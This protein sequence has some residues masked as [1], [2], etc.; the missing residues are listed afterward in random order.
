LRLFFQFSVPVNNSH[1]ADMDPRYAFSP[2]YF[3]PFRPI[4]NRLEYP[5]LFLILPCLPLSVGT[6]SPPLRL[7]QHLFLFLVPCSSSTS[8]PPH[9]FA[10][11]KTLTPLPPLFLVARITTNPGCFLHP[12]VPGSFRL[13]SFFLPDFSRLV[14]VLFSRFLA[15]FLV[16]GCTSPV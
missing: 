3:S 6:K 15:P 11:L 7:F 5:A 4:S 2:S 10:S 13:S 14:F 12:H 16:R 1:L 9:D 8:P